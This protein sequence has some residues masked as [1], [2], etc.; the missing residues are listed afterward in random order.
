MFTSMLIRIN[1]LS[2]GR[3]YRDITFPMGFPNGY[4]YPT[5]DENGN[6]LVTEFAM[7]SY[8]NHQTKSTQE[9]TENSAPGQLPRTVD[10]IAEDEFV[11]SCKPGDRVA[12]V[13]IYNSLPG[14]SKGSGNGVSRTILL[15]NN[16]SL[17]NKMSQNL[18]CSL[19]DIN[20][21]RKISQ[22]KDMFDLQGNSLAPCIYMGIRGYRKLRFDL[23]LVEMERT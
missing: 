20:N 15:A 12:I 8:K 4:V 1:L 23:C 5:R 16:A 17:L 6:L 7:C 19:D 21:F 10:I 2:V 18:Q 13:W 14:S 9:V 3:G 11:D 22:R